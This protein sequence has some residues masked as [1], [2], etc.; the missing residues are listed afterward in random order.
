[1]TAREAIPNYE[2][3][4]RE[5]TNFAIRGIK[6]VCAATGPREAGSEAER[7]AQEM[8]AAE[9]KSAADSV[10]IE[11]FRTAPRAFLGWIVWSV[12]GGVAAAVL[13]NIGYALI[14]AVLLALVLLTVA[15]EFGMYKQFI[16]PLYPQK[17]SHNVVAVR[18]PKGELKRRL[19]LCGHADSAYEWH[20][21][22]WG[23]KYFK[24]PKLLIVVMALCF[25]SIF[26]TFGAAVASL[27]AEHGGFGGLASL[28]ERPVWLKVLSYI[29]AVLAVPLLG[30]L[31]FKDN[32][33]VVMGASDNLSGCF[34]SMAVQ[35]MLADADLR[36]ENTELIVLC[37]GNEEGGLRGAKAFCK[38][39]DFSDAET[40]FI[41]LDTMT[42]YDYIGIYVT[43]LSGTVKHDAPLCAL[44]K[45]GARRAGYDIPYENLFFGGSDAAAATQ[46]GLHGAAFAAMDPAPAAYYHTR[47]DT[48]ESLNP[49]AMEACLDIISEI[50]YL[51]DEVGLAPYA[52]A[53]VSTKKA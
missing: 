22:Y 32:K 45:D 27:L 7:K 52:D 23:Y 51:Y 46:A 26:F 17:T 5:Y 21:T 28:A 44:M 39:H 3:K 41:A 10:E 43:D 42:D 49:K 53:K 36:L 11:P 1:M 6:K 19:I 18:K 14:A 24:S 4:R 34:C 15:L 47:L 35:K 29:A 30:G 50:T 38:T 40:S 2:Q 16:D 8:M 9:L 25:G 37:A 33:M 13:L 12:I 31:F 20:Y 48:V